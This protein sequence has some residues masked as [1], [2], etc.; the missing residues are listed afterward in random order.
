M[1]PEQII[2]YYRTYPYERSH[3]EIDAPRLPW[4]QSDKGGGDRRSDDRNFDCIAYVRWVRARIAQ[5]TD[6]QA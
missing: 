4:W 6:Q 2:E 5:E 3:E 1:S